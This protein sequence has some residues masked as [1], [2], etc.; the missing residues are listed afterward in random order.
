MS[1]K[2]SSFVDDT[3]RSEVL[4][5]LIAMIERIHTIFH[6]DTEKANVLMIDSTLHI[7]LPISESGD[8]H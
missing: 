6:V 7:S 8:S 3:Y 2:Q 1:R 4:K 5:H